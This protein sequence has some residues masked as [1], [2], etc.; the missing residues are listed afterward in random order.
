M[1]FGGTGLDLAN[2]L[3]MWDLDPHY[4]DVWGDPLPRITHEW[5]PNPYNMA[6]YFASSPGNTAYLNILTA[7]KATNI[8][9]GGTTVV[10]PYGTHNDWWGHH[11]RGGN[12]MGSDS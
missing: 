7:L 1:G 6:T 5:T 11:I 12:R 10:P 2:T 9:K 3:N 8:S 4:T